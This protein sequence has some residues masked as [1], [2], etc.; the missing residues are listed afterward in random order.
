MASATPAQNK[1]KKKTD[2]IPK[3]SSHVTF[4]VDQLSS[5]QECI[6][7]R[8]EWNELAWRSR[9]TTVFS[10]WEW[11]AAWWRHYGQRANLCVVTVRD[12][13]RLVGLLPLYLRSVSLAP[14]LPVR[15]MSLVGAG[16]D[17]SPDYLGPLL[18]PAYE[19]PVAT[20]LADHVLSRRELWDRLKLTDMSEGPFLRALAQRLG[21]ARISCEMAP[22]SQIAI[23]RLPASWDAYLAS[24]HRD[25]RKRI[26]YLRRHA[27]DARIVFIGH[28][29]GEAPGAATEALIELH[30]KRWQ[31]K[32]GGAFRSAC[33]T[34]FHREV[35]QLCHARDWVRLLRLES[36]GEIVAVFYCYRFR[37]EVLYFQSGFDPALERLSVGQVLMGY[38]MEAAIAEGART[39]DHLK[40]QHAYKSSWSN[41]A[42]AT[43]NLL[44]Y[45]TSLRG[46]LALLGR[47]MV[48]LKHSLI[49]DKGPAQ[50][51]STAPATSSG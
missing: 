17:T 2:A 8:H 26:R 24:V 32:G 29:P 21:A 39:F 35:I 48:K 6:P 44:A 40:G 20:T 43:Y 15:Q 25:R 41:D 13:G 51:E 14:G 33:Y 30:R 27:G 9:L 12:A 37:D 10:T 18:D 1:K 4:Q 34:D 23:M 22:C 36:A 3:A 47:S 50:H 5:P 11:Q 46:Q 31:A 16:G 38:A 45:N 28:D 49:P 7:L 42:R 19:E